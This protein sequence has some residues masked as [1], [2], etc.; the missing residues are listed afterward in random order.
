VN[1]SSK[2]V[3]A[4]ALVLGAGACNALIGLEDVSLRENDG[5]IGAASG[6]GSI[7]SGGT[8]GGRD[9]EGG[10]SNGLAGSEMGPGGDSALGGATGDAGAGGVT[11]AGS[12]TGGSP[13]EA[14]AGGEGGSGPVE[15]TCP[16]PGETVGGGK[17]KLVQFAPYQ[18]ARGRMAFSKD[19]KQA[20]VTSW[21]APTQHFSRDPTTGKLTAKSDAWV[22]NGEY[23]ALSPDDQH[24]YVGGTNA[25]QFYDHPLGPDGVLGTST[26]PLPP[27]YVSALDALSFGDSAIFLASGASIRSIVNG[28][29]S[30]TNR[31]PGPY[32]GVRTLSRGG[33]YLYWTEYAVTPWWPN[34]TPKVA[35]ARVNCDGTLEP[36]EAFTTTYSPVAIAV[37]AKADMAYLIHSATSGTAKNGY[38]DVIDFSEC[39]SDFSTCA[40]ADTL[41][42]ADIPGLSDP[43]GITMAPD[44]SAIYVTDHADGT[45]RILTLSLDDPLAPEIVQ[46]L[47][48]NVDY[49]GVTL[50]GELSGWHM[51]FYDG[52]LYIP[53]EFGEGVGVFKSGQ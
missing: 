48:P 40:P 5:S 38:I 8:E 2:L 49:G 15:P 13:S 51:S 37:C 35:R 31:A 19:G 10:M 45:S 25:L 36:R 47:S 53:F 7:S 22:Y 39:A 42:S 23:V 46:T 4:L 43:S 34:Q 14:G 33:D 32:D 30:S 29:Y 17:L 50:T 16:L 11:E 26:V 52:Y 44:C 1:R 20:Y 24:L 21:G 28:T 9:G 27:G 12:G 3:S 41:T 18:G 6:E